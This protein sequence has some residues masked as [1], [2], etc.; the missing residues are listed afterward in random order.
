MPNLEPFVQLIRAAFFLAAAVLWLAAAL[1]RLVL[2]LLVPLLVRSGMQAFDWMGG[3]WHGAR[4]PLRTRDSIVLTAGA[5]LWMTARTLEDG[6]RQL[7]RA[8]RGRRR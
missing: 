1:V 2:M 8:G 3:R 6:A 5:V 4:R 7:D